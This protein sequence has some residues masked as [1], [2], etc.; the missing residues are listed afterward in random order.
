MVVF[1]CGET[2][3]GEVQGAVSLERCFFLMVV[4]MCRGIYTLLHW[5]NSIKI[6]NCF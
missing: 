4:F 6:A 3:Y 2:Y 1:M 5:V